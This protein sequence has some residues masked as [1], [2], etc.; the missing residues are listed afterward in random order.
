[1]SAGA[2]AFALKPRGLRPVDKII[3]IIFADAID[4]YSGELSAPLSVIARAAE[5]SVRTAHDSICRLCEMGFLEKKAEFDGNLQKQSTYALGSEF[6]E[7]E[8]L[9][10]LGSFFRPEAARGARNRAVLRSSPLGENCRVEV[11]VPI[12]PDEQ[13]EVVTPNGNSNLSYARRKKRAY[14]DENPPTLEEWVDCSKN[15]PKVAETLMPVVEAEQAYDWYVAHGWCQ[16]DGT[17]LIDWKAVLRRWAR[18]WKAKNPQAYANAKRE[19]DTAAR[20]P[21]S[22]RGPYAE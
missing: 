22:Y 20:T 13:D 7:Q 4:G 21:S 18:S 14:L 3:L 17:R 2:V 5:V 11:N 10:P 16:K 15:D 8:T 12:S 9:L 6:R 19:R 1:M